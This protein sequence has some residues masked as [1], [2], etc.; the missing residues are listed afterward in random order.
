[1]AGG[2]TSAARETMR[3]SSTGCVGVNTADTDDYKLYITQTESGRG[4]R[5]QSSTAADIAQ[6][7]VR[8]SVANT[9]NHSEIALITNGASGG[10]CRLTFDT[11]QAPIWTM[12]VKASDNSFRFQSTSSAGLT[13]PDL[14]IA[15]D[16]KIGIGRA[17]DSVRHI[18]TNY[19]HT[20]FSGSSQTGL[21]VSV[22]GFKTGSSQSSTLTGIMSDVHPST[23]NDQNWTAPAA[24]VAF[25]AFPRT[26]GGVWGYY[27]CNRLPY[28]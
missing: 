5:V 14:T 25:E 22:S 3:I 21:Q 4:I 26:I 17:P 28:G 10:D 12:G 18:F 13:T 16:G 27:W 7:M 15:A 23:S 8:N 1:M 24:M 6:V 9:L 2:G 20:E 19:D 11:S